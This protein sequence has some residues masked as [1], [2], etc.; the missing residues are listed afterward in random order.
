MCHMQCSIL[1]VSVGSSGVRKAR[2]V[3]VHQKYQLVLLDRHRRCLASPPSEA[4]LA[5]GTITS[6]DFLVHVIRDV[7]SIH[8]QRFFDVESHQQV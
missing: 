6:V 8:H 1:T 7:F 2:G 3:F 5:S 4:S